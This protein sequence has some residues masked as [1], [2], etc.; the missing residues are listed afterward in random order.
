MILNV[1]KDIYP[2]V[3]VMKAAY[4]FTDVAYIYIQQSEHD[5]IIDITAKTATDTV[6]EEEF[7]NELLSQAVRY[8]LYKQTKDVRQLIITRALASTIVGEQ[9]EIIQPNQEFSEDDILKDWFD[10]EDKTI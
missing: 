2:K 7:K 9:K 3:A 1:P 6:A 8:E 4:Q 10:H 5:Y